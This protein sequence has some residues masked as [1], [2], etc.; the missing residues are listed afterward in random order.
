MGYMKF[1]CTH[2]K[3]WT[4]QTP[5]QTPSKSFFSAFLWCPHNCI[6][7][8]SV[9]YN[10]PS[11]TRI[12][13][14]CVL[15]CHVPFTNTHALGGSRFWFWVPFRKFGIKIGI[16][17][18]YDCTTLFQFLF[19]L[20]EVQNELEQIYSIGIVE[21]LRRSMDPLCTMVTRNRM[22]FDLGSQSDDSQ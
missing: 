16:N 7:E 19:Q 15:A 9:G 6:F 10:E 3:F 2:I 4:H 12:T 22:I 1:C 13:N 8:D 11:R 18:N 21:T 20:L 17:L 14:L 5:V